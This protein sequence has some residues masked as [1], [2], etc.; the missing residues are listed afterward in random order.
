LLTHHAPT[1]LGCLVG[2][3]S[4]WKLNPVLEDLLLLLYVR[5]WKSP[6]YS[7]TSHYVKKCQSASYGFLVLSLLIAEPCFLWVIIILTILKVYL[8]G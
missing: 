4:F 8:L 5:P 3:G 6:G 1:C 7:E 2:L